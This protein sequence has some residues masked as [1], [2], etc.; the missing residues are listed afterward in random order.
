MQ[1]TGHLQDPIEVGWA[2][3]PAKPF[4]PVFKARDFTPGFL[5]GQVPLSFN[6]A[7]LARQV[8]FGLRLSF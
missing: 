2:V 6:S 5:A 1:H 4:N 8:Q 7:D 3:N